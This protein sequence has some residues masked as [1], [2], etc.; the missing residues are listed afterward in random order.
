L[1]TAININNAYGK[2]KFIQMEKKTLQLVKELLIIIL[3][4]TIVIAIGMF[5]VN[6]TIGY[7]YKSQFLQG[8]CYLCAQE[9]DH[10]KD[11][12][13]ESSTIYTN[14]NGEIIN[15]KELV[16]YEINF[17]HFGN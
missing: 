13:K 5:A 3:I 6:Q 4:I 9:N 17:S 10:L 14:R 15:K 16:N 7:Y 1:S 12:L 2:N 8:P 11:C